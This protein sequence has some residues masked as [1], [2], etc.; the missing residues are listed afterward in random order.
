MALNVK[1]HKTHKMTL[2]LKQDN[3]RRQDTFWR[4]TFKSK[5]L[6][7]FINGSQKSGYLGAGVTDWKGA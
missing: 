3:Y 7:L 1:S 6:L 2:A 5:Y 4:K